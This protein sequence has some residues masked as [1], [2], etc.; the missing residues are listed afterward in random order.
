MTIDTTKITPEKLAEMNDSLI[1]DNNHLRQRI[2]ELEQ[3]LQNIAARIHRDGGHH[4]DEHGLD[5]A[6]EDADII[7]A[8]TY[9]KIEELEQ[10]LAKMTEQ[11][12]KEYLSAIDW[13]GKHQILYEQNLALLGAIEKKDAILEK[14][15]CIGNG[16]S[17]GNSIGNCLAIDALA[18]QR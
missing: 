1:V 11:A 7:V 12:R 14:I 13:A 3:Q 10:Q 15:A 2:A 6:I 16:D 18:I 4:E 17:H 8:N 9:G 5:K